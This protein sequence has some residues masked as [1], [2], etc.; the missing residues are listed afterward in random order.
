MCYVVFYKLDHIPAYNYVNLELVLQVEGSSTQ[1]CKKISWEQFSDG[2]I[3]AYAV[4]RQQNITCK[5]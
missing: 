5:M 1:E 2:C 4:L 3:E